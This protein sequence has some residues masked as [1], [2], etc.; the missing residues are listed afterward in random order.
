M[1]QLPEPFLFWKRC[2]CFAQTGRNLRYIRRPSLFLTTTAHCTNNRFNHC[3]F[4]MLSAAPLL[5]LK[6]S[7]RDAPGGR[8]TS[9]A[10]TAVKDS[11]P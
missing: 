7:L 8:S 11:W 3:C 9:F 10:P 4:G 2:T 1:Q 5:A 6:V